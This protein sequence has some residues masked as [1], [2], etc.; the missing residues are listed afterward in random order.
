MAQWGN[1]MARRRAMLRSTVMETAAIRHIIGTLWTV[2]IMIFRLCTD[3]PRMVP[4][5]GFKTRG[6][7]Q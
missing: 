1:P 2:I 3:A 6:G 7:L 5:R 4:C